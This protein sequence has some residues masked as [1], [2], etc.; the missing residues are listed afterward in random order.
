MV[1]DSDAV[2]VTGS[3]VDSYLEGRHVE[4]SLYEPDL[5]ASHQQIYA[6]PP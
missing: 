4:G 5:P 6:H 1:G 2:G 3:R